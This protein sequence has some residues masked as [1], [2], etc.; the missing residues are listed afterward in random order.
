MKKEIAMLIIGTLLIF[1]FLG[2]NNNKKKENI[3][4]KF[5]IWTSSPSTFW[6]DDKDTAWGIVWVT[7][8]YEYYIEMPNGSGVGVYGSTVTIK[9]ENGDSKNPVL[10]R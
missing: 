7:E 10:L 5:D 6:R 8:I 4:T 1:L 3:A 2:C 9:H